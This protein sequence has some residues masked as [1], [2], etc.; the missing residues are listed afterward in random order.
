MGNNEPAL[1][2][3]LQGGMSKQWLEWYRNQG[4]GHSLRE[5]RDEALRRLSLKRTKVEAVKEPDEPDLKTVHGTRNPEWVRWYRA[6]KG[7][8]LREAVDELDRRINQLKS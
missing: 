7:C 8:L 4:E 6:V 3:T 1:E 2:G 5:A